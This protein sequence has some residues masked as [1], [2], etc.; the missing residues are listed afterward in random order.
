[1]D[2][3]LLRF[4]GTDG[5]MGLRKNNVDVVKIYTKNRSICV[6]WGKNV[7]PYSS[8]SS[9]LRNWEEIA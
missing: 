3:V 8:I 7:C 1:M 2:T 9:F 4:I 6:N 5:S